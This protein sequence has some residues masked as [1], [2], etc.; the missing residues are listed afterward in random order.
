VTA[1]LDARKR[2]R[3]ETGSRSV[4]TPVP[5]DRQHPPDVTEL[6]KRE[7]AEQPQSTVITV[8]GRLAPED[9]IRH[10]IAQSGFPGLGGI[11]EPRPWNT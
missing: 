5:A 8:E 4:A 7:P 1:R 2:P 9:L 10:I 6:P 11:S 3:V